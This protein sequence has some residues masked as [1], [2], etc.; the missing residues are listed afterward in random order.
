[1]RTNLLDYTLSELNEIV[2]SLGESKFRASQLY[3]AM[4]NGKDYDCVELC[5]L[6]SNW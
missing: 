6:V 3:T 5:G 1:M 4:L 2:V